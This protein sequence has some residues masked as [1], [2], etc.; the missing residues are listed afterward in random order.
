MSVICVTLSPN[1]KLWQNTSMLGSDKQRQMIV[2]FFKGTTHLNYKRG[3]V[4]IRPQDAPG[5]IFFIEQGFVKAYAITKYGEENLLLV[6]CNENVFPLIWAFTGL[7][8]EITYEAMEPTSLWRCSREEYLAFL[9]KKPEVL[10]AILEMAVDA[11]RL[12]SDRVITLSYRSVRE[13]IASFLLTCADRFGVETPE[14]IMINAPLRR[15]DI[16]SSVNAARE[17]ASRELS[18][19]ASRGLIAA[20]GDRNIVI[21]DMTKLRAML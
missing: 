13:R 3:E 15:F 14:G 5:G 20:D 16:A 4:I 10:P 1:R 19:L 2:D 18:Q 17:T 11:Y 21:R 8:R 12:H 6:R 7:H 9:D